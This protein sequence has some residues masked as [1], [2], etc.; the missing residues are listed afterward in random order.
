ML[1]F[2]EGA[3]ECESSLVVVVGELSGD[4]LTPEGLLSNCLSL[5]LLFIVDGELFASSTGLL[6]GVECA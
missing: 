1:C 4:L 5:C 6:F 2:S 3:D